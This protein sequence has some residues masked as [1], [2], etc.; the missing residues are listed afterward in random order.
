MKPNSWRASIPLTYHLQQRSLQKCLDP[1][2]CTN[3]PKTSLHKSTQRPAQTLHTKT[4]HICQLHKNELFADVG[5]PGSGEGGLKDLALCP[6][7]SSAQKRVSA[8]GITGSGAAPGPAK[9]SAISLRPGGEAARPRKLW[10]SHPAHHSLF[11]APSSWNN[12][13]PSAH[14]A[15]RLRPSLPAPPSQ[16]RTAPRVPLTGPIASQAVFDP[17]SAIPARGGDAERPR[18]P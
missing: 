11:P 6:S 9:N 16:P 1:E 10:C 3:R 15:Q 14:G 2:S 8:P 7:A 5:S 18:D 17:P 4:L 12:A 13:A